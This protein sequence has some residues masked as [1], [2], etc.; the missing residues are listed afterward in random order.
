MAKS[1]AGNRRSRP[2]QQSSGRFV[3]ALAS[4]LC[5]YLAA[6]VFD[7]ASLS[8]WVNKNVLNQNNKNSKPVAN[9]AVKQSELPKP[10]F[11]FY[12]LLSKDNS[13][14]VVNRPAPATTTA[15]PAAAVVATQ[16]PAITPA[17]QAAAQQ[18]TQAVA[19]A[20]SR[21]VAPVGKPAPARGSY[22]I[23]IASFNRRGDA[24]HLKASLL[25]RGFDVG[26][27]PVTQRNMT[28]YRVI[29]GPF[30]SRSDAEKAQ[31]VVARSERMQGMIRKV[32]G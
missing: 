13:A 25:M 1:Y 5:G 30:V 7:V 16:K 8:A 32:E 24:E 17:V 21:P 27:V 26:V 28:W 12:T 9:V 22:Q 4:F 23:Q 6:T 2:Q 31:A 20:E 18:A 14:P 3:V 10:K 29:I 19:V 11:E 15:A